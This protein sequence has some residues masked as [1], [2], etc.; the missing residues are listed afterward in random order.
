MIVTRSE[1]A[2]VRL[3]SDWTRIGLLPPGWFCGGGK[4]QI[5]SKT[6]ISKLSL[7]HILYVHLQNGFYQAKWPVCWMA[8]LSRDLSFTSFGISKMHVFLYVFF[9]QTF[10]FVHSIIHFDSFLYFHQNCINVHSW[11]PTLRKDFVILQ[12]YWWLFSSTKHCQYFVW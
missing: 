8:L 2:N 3:N 10:G 11:C 5:F 6:V 12:L 9:I 1:Q 7:G 4:Y